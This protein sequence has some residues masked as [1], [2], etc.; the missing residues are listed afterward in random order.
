V[1]ELSSFDGHYLEP[2][3]EEILDGRA[4]VATGP[5]SLVDHVGS[6]MK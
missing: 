3:V 5:I 1:I 4:N 6:Y 2:F